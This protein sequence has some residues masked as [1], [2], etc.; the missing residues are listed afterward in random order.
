MPPVGMLLYRMVALMPLPVRESE[1]FPCAVIP[2]WACAVKTE[3]SEAN[4][5]SVHFINSKVRRNDDLVKAV[6][7]LMHAFND[8]RGTVD[9]AGSPLDFT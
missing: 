8:E 1:T 4:M 6:Q 3:N 7:R 5:R 2:S 9:E